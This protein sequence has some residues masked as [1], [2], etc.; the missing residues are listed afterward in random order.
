MRVVRGST[1]G[2]R[3]K[4]KAERE[5]LSGTGLGFAAHVATRDGIGDGEGLDGEGGGDACAV[6]CID[7]ARVDAERGERGHFFVVSVVIEVGRPG[8]P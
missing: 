8:T 4:R 2:E 7:E 5:C 6:E 3:E 1:T